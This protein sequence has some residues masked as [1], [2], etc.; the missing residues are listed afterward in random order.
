M[1]PE[2][3]RSAIEIMRDELVAIEN[4]ELVNRNRA[5]Q[6]ALDQ[7]GMRMA[8]ISD[9]VKNIV[10]TQALILKQSEDDIAETNKKTLRI[11]NKCE[12][13]MGRKVL[14]MQQALERFAPGRAA[15]EAQGASAQI[16]DPTPGETTAANE[17]PAAS[18]A[19]DTKTPPEGGEYGIEYIE[20]VAFNKAQPH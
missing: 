17:A 15:T 4:M 16:E 18:P 6:S 8:E 12:V 13:G 20:G 2:N 5:R 14:T 10:S 19:I 7:L 1:I 11:I 9:E 3:E